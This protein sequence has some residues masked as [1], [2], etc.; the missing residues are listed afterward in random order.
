MQRLRRGLA[1]VLLAGLLLPGV[2]VPAGGAGAAGEAALWSALADGS[3]AALMRHAFAPG[4]GDP[5]DF[6]LAD[7]ATQRNL[8][9]TGRDQAR[10]TGDD[11]RR[12]GIEAATVLSSAWC[13]SRETAEQLG[14]GPVAIRPA[15]NSF[16]GDR[17]QAAARTAGLRRILAD[18]RGQG[19]LILV[20][21]QVNITALTGGW[22]RSGE[23]V[24]VSA[25]AEARLLGR[26][27]L[28]AL[29]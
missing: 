19:P 14:L 18:W 11:F 15:L 9:A 13:R 5:P 28:L 16:F 2:L 6:D 4:T 21:H 17:S 10:R 8:D 24:V 29:D 22:V 27:P 23:I 7:C 20:T 3:A 26:L 1:G 12:N 25:D